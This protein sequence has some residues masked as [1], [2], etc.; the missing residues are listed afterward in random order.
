MKELQTNKD[1]MMDLLSGLQKNG[2]QSVMLF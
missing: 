2:Q 1:G